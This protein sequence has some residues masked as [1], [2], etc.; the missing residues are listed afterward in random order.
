MN[1]RVKLIDCKY[2]LEPEVNPQDFRKLGISSINSWINSQKYV[3]LSDEKSR[4]EDDSMIVLEADD[5]VGSSSA[6]ELMEGFI[7]DDNLS[8]KSNLVE[9]PGS[10]GVEIVEDRED[11]DDGDDG[12]AAPEGGKIRESEGDVQMIEMINRA[13]SR[14]DSRSGNEADQGSNC[15]RGEEEDDDRPED[16]ERMRY[17][18]HKGPILDIKVSEESDGGF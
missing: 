2:L 12:V 14:A 3:I 18:V 13:E 11:A 17:T 8:V 4:S 5:N 10:S 9:L 1:C 16:K 6:V 15:G 7:E